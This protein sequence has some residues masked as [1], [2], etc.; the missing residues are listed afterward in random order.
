MMNSCGGLVVDTTS[1]FTSP[2]SVR[3]VNGVG[4]NVAGTGLGGKVAVTVAAEAR[5]VWVEEM[6]CNGKQAESPVRS[7]R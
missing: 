4:A 7:N 5:T 3:Q 1:C 2:G 6:P